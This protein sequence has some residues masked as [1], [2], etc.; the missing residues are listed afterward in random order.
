MLSLMN[1]NSQE[2]SESDSAAADKLLIRTTDYQLKAAFTMSVISP[3]LD[4]AGLS[5]FGYQFLLQTT[6]IS[7]IPPIGIGCVLSDVG[8]TWQVFSLLN[9]VRKKT[10]KEDIFKTINE[11][12]IN[13]N[14]NK[15]INLARNF[16]L[17]SG[18][19]KSSG[20]LLAVGGVAYGA[21]THNS[22]NAPVA[23]VITGSCI[24]LAGLGTTVAV[25]FFIG[26]ARKIMRSNY[27]VLLTF[28]ISDSGI[29]LVCKFPQ[30][31]KD[32]LKQTVK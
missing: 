6:G 12:N 3:A 13:G 5:M 4:I 11:Y 28:N 14:F 15:K 17:A 7:V 32:Y 27:P 20:I 22:G 29:G 26:K 1:S 18:I 16:S 8:V 21:V 9:K 24:Y 23:L 19:L 2:V 30:P 25:P 10:G 31:A